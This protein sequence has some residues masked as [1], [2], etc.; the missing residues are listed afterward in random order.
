M[1]RIYFTLF[2]LSTLSIKAQNLI[3]SADKNPALVGE[4]IVLKFTINGKATNFK[5]PDFNGLQVL[6]GP[7]PST[8]NSYTIINGK[9][10]SS[11]STTYSFY[12]KGLKK[13]IYNITQAS[14]NLNGKLI[15]SK[16]I[17]I[18]IVKAKEKSDKQKKSLSDNLFIKV[19]TSKR[20]IKVGE[21]IIV[22]YS[23]YTRYDLQNTELSKLPALNGFWVKDLKVSSQF[24]RQVVEGVAYNV[25]VVKKS[26]LTAQ[27]KGKLSID[28]LELKCDILIQNSRNNR[29][30]FANFFGRNYQT[31]EEKIS[32][33]KI[34]IN[35]TDLPK[36]PDGFNGAIGNINIKSELD[37]TTISTND[38]IT[39]KVTISGTGNIELIK[40]LDIYFPDNFEVYDPKISDKIFEGGLKKS[41][42]TF[43]YLLIPRFKGEYSIPSVN[44]I[45]YNTKNKKY[46][47]K[48]TSEHNII[49]KG[50]LN[51][52]EQSIFKQ[53]TLKKEQIDINHIYQ[54]GFL[55]KSDNQK[56]TQRLLY[57]LI[58]LPILI[59]II[60]NIY[61]IT[62]SKKNKET[63]SLKNKKANK[64]AQKRLKIAQKCIKES[65]FSV[66]FEEIEK[67]LWG[68]FADKFKVDSAKLSKETIAKYFNIS[69][70]DK[71]TEEEFISL[72]N[73]CEFIRYSPAENK[74]TQMEIILVKAKNI[75]IKVETALK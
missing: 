33:Q 22:T 15:K 21:Q 2:V 34:T 47:Y 17:S 25:A 37:N 48:K 35:V 61:D 68:Y 23:L 19:N 56:F 7:N 4:Q 53:K 38:A 39:Y 70:I 44:L 14:I 1:K 60:L 13:G 31:Q 71:N 10:E 50:S 66:F 28:P 74:N 46:E 30:P 6:S 52:E 3:V 36:S 72:L 9:S 5:S 64:I 75:I 69:K 51:E 65:N 73:E 16:K 62:K 18:E 8:Q 43:E 29:D 58:F 55:K 54:K 11:S 42:K 63:S 24:E 27:K 40:P 26:V 49:V 12:L 45:V 41:Y 32:S 59:L 67:S 57:L 20:N